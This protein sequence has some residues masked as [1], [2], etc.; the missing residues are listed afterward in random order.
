VTV[1]SEDPF[2][3]SGP[4]PASRAPGS[5]VAAQSAGDRPRLPR[6]RIRSQ[7]TLRSI[8]RDMLGD[9][10]RAD[11]ILELNREVIDDAGQLTTGQEIDL[12]EDAR[13]ARRS[14]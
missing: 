9:S 12:P 8:A 5:L 13:T 4:R 11:E 6:Y 1:P 2:D 7:E 10:R 3:D 14:R